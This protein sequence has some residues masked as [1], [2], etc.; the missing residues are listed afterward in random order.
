MEVTVRRAGMQTTVQDL[1]RPGHRADGVPLGGAMDRF[2]LR[3][4]NLLVGNEENAAALEFALLGPELA[5]GGDALVAVTGGDFG[6]L[7]RWQPIRVPAGTVLRFNAAITGCRGYLAIAGGFDADR[8]L[9]SASTFLRGVFG[10][11]RG[12]A[13]RDGDTL[14]APDVRREPADHWRIDARILPPYG[15]EPNLRVLPGAQAGEYDRALFALPYQVTAQSDRMGLR[16]KGTALARQADR[17]LLSSAVAPGTVQAPPDGQP[18]ILMADAQ[19]IGGYPQI[20]HVITA[21]L[22]LVAQLRPGDA[23]RFVE[24]SL[25]E[26]HEATLARERALAMLRYGL[27]QKLG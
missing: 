24:V 9:G 10:G 14:T 12:R 22:P 20:A 16:L 18:I 25:A 2:A 7:P 6:G 21:D 5:F 3:V 26:A 4:A 27:A 13:L 19:T 23:L 15:A 11:F 17:E 8:V 1:G